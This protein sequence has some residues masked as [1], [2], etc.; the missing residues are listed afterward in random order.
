MQTMWQ[1]LK[2]GVRGLVSRPAFAGLAVLT[3][4]LGIGAA[5]TIFSVIQNVLLDP[6]P[7]TDARRVANV[8]VRNLASGQQGGRSFFRVPEFLDYLEQS[9]VFEEVIGGTNEEVLLTTGESTELFSGGRVTPNTFSFLGVPAA[10]GRTLGDAD[11][12]A[13]APPVFV[14]AYKM[15]SAQYNLDPSILGRSFTLDGVPTTLVGIMPKRFTKLGSDL[16]RPVTLSRADAAQRNRFFMFQGKLKP[17]VT[18]E[19]ATADLDVIGHRLAG[20]YPENYPPQFKVVAVPWVDNIVGRFRQ[21]LYTIAAAVGLL[22]LIACSNVAN[23]LLARAAAREKEMA[24]RS[25]LGASRLRLVQQLLLESGVLAVAG[26]LAGCFVAYAGLKG[27]VLLMPEGLIPREADIRMSVPVLLFSLGAG[28]A[29]ALLFGLVPAL[30]SARR[31]MVE[32]L[33][34]AGKGVSGGFRGG[35]LRSAIVVVEVALSLM[36]LVSAGLLMRSFVR[37]QTVD[38]GMNPDNVLVARTPLPRG[39]YPTAEAKQRF[40]D[41]L[42][43]RL[44]ALPGVTSATTIS[45]LPPFGG[46]GSEIQIPGTTH[47]ERWNAIFQLVSHGYF[48]TLGIRTLRGRL[49][50]ETEVTAG[51]KVA[52]INQTLVNRFFG[53]AD[54]IG[55]QIELTMLASVPEGPVPSPTFEIVGVI[56]DAKNN[57]IQEPA[58]PEVFIPYT[59]TPAFERAI[60][61]R[62]QGEP[63]AMLNTVRREIW[64]IDRGIAI[65]LT[66]TLNEYLT[67][68]AYA[69]PRFTLVLLGVFSGVGLV[70]VAIGVYSVI[71]YT[72]SRQT[73]EIGI[74]LALGASHGTVLRLV[75]FQGLRL[76]CVG[77]IL[78]LMG[79]LAT[80]RLVERELWN[81]SKYDPLT[82]AVVT[83]VMIVVGLFACYVPARRAMRVNPIVALR[84]E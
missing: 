32:P 44:H 36:L 50:T 5:T 3:L 49:L 39:Q 62:T 56:A 34:D 17:G 33:K 31:N 67:R 69:A 6:F 81:V 79:S 68:F 11:A 19:Q 28:V 43:R 21:S 41:E 24:V 54:P 57:G 18:M 27:L 38:L 74:R 58:G 13:D 25:S 76:I 72:V 82:F 2:Y 4:G 71:A 51:R 9:S 30:Q 64:A 1:D 84:Y 20:S 52:V 46:I 77:L 70:L 23:M 12:K 80:T 59:V 40:F 42:M 73:H 60:L 16:W 14:M 22:L 66:G 53:N 8:Q 26:A 47:T 7:Y 75:S 63:G 37:L 65:T 55:R 48:H 29:T 78:G 61:V 10:L 45:G 15:W 35:R 83:A